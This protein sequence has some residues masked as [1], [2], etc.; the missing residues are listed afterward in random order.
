MVA[1]CELRRVWSGRL[2]WATSVYW[3]GWSPTWSTTR[4]AITPHQA[5]STSP[6]G[7][8]TARRSF[9]SST[10]G[11]SSWP[12]TFPASSSRS[13][14]WA[15]N[16]PATGTAGGWVSPSCAIASAHDASVTAQALPDGGLTIEVAFPLPDRAS[17]RKRRLAGPFGRRRRFPGPLLGPRDPSRAEILDQRLYPGQLDPSLGRG[18]VRSRRGRATFEATDPEIEAVRA[19]RDEDTGPVHSIATPGWRRGPR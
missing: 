13:S 15:R 19:R 2:L 6:R 17:W 16:A 10:P 12:R 1:G 5:G 18:P 11:R 8:T 14:D 4:S 3:S 9:A 7:P